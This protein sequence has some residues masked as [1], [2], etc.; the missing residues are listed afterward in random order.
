MIKRATEIVALFILVQSSNHMQSQTATPN[1]KSIFWAVILTAGWLLLWFVPWQSLPMLSMWL[2]L[3]V[4]LILFI[5]PG[6]CIY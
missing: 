1:R 2:K 3:G 6:F 5:V 4:V